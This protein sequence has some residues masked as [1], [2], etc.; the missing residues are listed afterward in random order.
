MTDHYFLVC[1]DEREGRDTVA[2]ALRE[3][4][5]SATGEL[6]GMRYQVVANPEENIELL[7][8]E[9]YY[10]WNVVLLPLRALSPGEQFSRARRLAEFFAEL[11]VP[12][13]VA[14]SGARPPRSLGACCRTSCSPPGSRPS[15]TAC[16]PSRGWPGAAGST[17][18]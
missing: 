12:A 10:P 13:F 6:D 15:C 17:A 11:G 16:G 14:V 7:G 9:L 1:V 8:H 3:Y 2:G 4:G 5:V 18:R